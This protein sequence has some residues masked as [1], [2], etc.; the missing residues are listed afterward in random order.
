M[1]GTSG[2]WEGG[3]PESTV[4]RERRDAPARAATAGGA[5]E[6]EGGVEVNEKD[7]EDERGLE[8][9][10]A[11]EH[12]LAVEQGRA[13]ERDDRGGEGKVGRHFWRAGCAGAAARREFDEEAEGRRAEAER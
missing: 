7:A 6:A 1:A 4:S 9:R 10:A 3:A 13:G 11:R 2:A 8:G 5:G 12:R